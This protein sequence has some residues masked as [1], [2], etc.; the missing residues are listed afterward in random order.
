MLV[1]PRDLFLPSPFFG[2]TLYPADHT[3]A[4]SSKYHQYDNNCQIGSSASD[5]STAPD[6]I[7]SCPLPISMNVQ[8]I[9]IDFFFKKELF[10][11]CTLT[12]SPPRS[13]ISIHLVAQTQHC[14]CN[15]DSSPFLIFTPDPLQSSAHPS[16]SVVPRPAVSPE[17]GKKYI[18]IP[19]IP[20]PTES[21]VRLNH[22]FKM[23][24]RSLH[25]LRSE[26]HCSKTYVHSSIQNL[27]PII[28][29]KHISDFLSISMATIL[30]IIS[31]LT[32]LNN[33]LTI[34]FSALRTHSLLRTH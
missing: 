14:E 34:P 25:T 12:C 6:F 7:S 13:G 30:T 3:W 28:Y 27:C 9:S 26:N 31:H 4:H 21:G 24:S 10:N 1:R 20:R 19:P 32:Y 23:P 18:L 5:L 33:L 22:L 17:K 15:F 16:Q 11:S 8:K 2:Y 29:S